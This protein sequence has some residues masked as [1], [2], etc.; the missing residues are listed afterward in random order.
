MLLQV[1]PTTFSQ[2]CA[3]KFLCCLNYLPLPDL[4][5]TRQ[6]SLLVLGL[7][8]GVSAVVLVTGYLLSQEEAQQKKMIFIQLLPCL[9]LGMQ[10]FVTTTSSSSTSS[11][12]PPPAVGQY[13]N[14]IGG[15]H[16]LPGWLPRLPVQLSSTRVGS[17]WLGSLDL[18]PITQSK[19]HLAWQFCV[20]FVGKLK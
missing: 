20:A 1:D 18:L 8:H 15:Q 11:R 10:I 5:Y 17:A 7:A 3:L 16:L 19:R 2:Q 13:S 4:K 14:H 6:W 12:E 9:V